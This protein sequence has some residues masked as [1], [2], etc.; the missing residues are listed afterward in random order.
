M[1]DQHMRQNNG[2]VGTNVQH[3]L[4]GHFVLGDDTPDVVEVLHRAV[5]SLLVDL[6]PDGFPR[7]YD[8]LNKSDKFCLI[9][10]INLVGIRCWRWPG[11]D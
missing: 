11:D 3:W 4:E 6:F 9:P 5:A 8:L 7:V 2:Q 1:N 10:S